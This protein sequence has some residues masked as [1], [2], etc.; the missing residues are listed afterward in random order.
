MGEPAADVR[1]VRQGPVVA[2]LAHQQRPHRPTARALP[3]G[4]PT[5]GHHR[6]GA[7]LDLDPVAA[8]LPRVV[9]AVGALCHDP[10]EPL[11]HARLQECRAVADDVLGRAPALCVQAE[12]M[13]TLPTLDVW[14]GHERVPV[15]PQ[16]VEQDVHRGDFVLEA[17][18]LR[19]RVDVHAPLQRLEARATVFV[20]RDD[21]TVEHRV[22]R[23]E[24]DREPA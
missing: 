8:P 21:L 19:L 14:Q 13:Q 10:L 17:P 18:D 6:L 23:S 11:L 1:Q 22:T 16:E 20:E 15:E 12:L 24:L 4:E 2:A 9:G 7:A 3:L 5:D